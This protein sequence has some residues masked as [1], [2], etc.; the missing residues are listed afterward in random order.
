M[1]AENSLD[2]PHGLFCKGLFTSVLYIHFDPTFSPGWSLSFTLQLGLVHQTKRF[3]AVGSRSQYILFT[4]QNETSIGDESTILSFWSIVF[5]LEHIPCNFN[6]GVLIIMHSH[7]EA[8]SPC[9]YL[10]VDDFFI[11]SHTRFGVLQ[12]ETILYHTEIAMKKWRTNYANQT[13]CWFVIRMNVYQIQLLF[14]G[15]Q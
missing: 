4:K 9:L 1:K 11:S 12:R 13:F 7:H 2:L 5:H 15:I 3:S 14:K 6:H 8:Y 10:R